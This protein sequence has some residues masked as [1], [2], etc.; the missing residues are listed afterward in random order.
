MMVLLVWITWKMSRI[1]LFNSITNLLMFIIGIIFVLL[2]WGY[3]YEWYSFEKSGFIIDGTNGA[4]VRY[5]V[6]ALTLFLILSK[7]FRLFKTKN[8]EDIKSDVD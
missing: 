3:A 5:S 7:I 6:S 2:Q 4:I 8:E 1:D